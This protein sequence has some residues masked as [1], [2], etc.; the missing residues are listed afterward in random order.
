MLDRRHARYQR[1]ADLLLLN[2]FTCRTNK[3]RSGF[4]ILPWRPTISAT[5]SELATWTHSVMFILLRFVIA[6]AEEGPW[7][8]MVT[9]GP[10]RPSTGDEPAPIGPNAGCFPCDDVEYSETLAFV[11]DRAKLASCRAKESP[12]LGSSWWTADGGATSPGPNP[13][14][15]RLPDASGVGR[16][17]S[18]LAGIGTKFCHVANE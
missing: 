6:A 9:G 18:T 3:I 15:G 12:A 2:N 8:G 4:V 1:M 10:Q 7:C 13:A 16:S 17:I 14:E 11:V 5:C